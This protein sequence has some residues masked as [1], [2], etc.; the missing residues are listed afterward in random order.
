M[1]IQ[2]HAQC[3]DGYLEWYLIVSHP[4]IISPVEHA[5]DDF[6]P[7]NAEGPS[8]DVPLPPPPPFGVADHHRL[9]IIAVLTY[10]L[11]GLV[12]PDGEIYTLVSQITHIVRRGPM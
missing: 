10:N 7:S 11:M 1:R 8:D 3:V 6:R 12:N 9:Q 2:F 4:C 5:D